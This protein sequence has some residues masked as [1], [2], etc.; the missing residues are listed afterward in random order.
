M[1]LLP[2]SANSEHAEHVLS[3]L[4]RE[5]RAVARVLDLQAQR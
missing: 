5:L 4:R 3:A 2:D 1:E